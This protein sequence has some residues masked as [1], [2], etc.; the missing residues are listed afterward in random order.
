ML[1]LAIIGVIFTPA[2]SMIAGMAV[3]KATQDWN[4]WGCKSCG[5]SFIN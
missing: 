1:A 5:A 3:Y 2:G 4:N